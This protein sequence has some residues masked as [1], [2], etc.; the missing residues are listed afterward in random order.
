LVPH[1]PQLFGSNCVSL[2][3]PLHSVSELGQ[4]ELPHELLTHFPAAHAIPQPPQLSG[5]FEASTHSPPPQLI[6]GAAHVQVPETHVVPPVHV[7]PQPPQSSGS[8]S[9]SMQA[10]AQSASGVV[11]LSAH[12]PLSQT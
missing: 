7:I 1:F 11:Q 5:S 12:V 3:T 2:H 8:V 9:G 10:L 6:I 4:P